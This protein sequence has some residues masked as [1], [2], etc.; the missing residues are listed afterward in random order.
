MSN[1]K[2]LKEEKVKGFVVDFTGT[3][4]GKRIEYTNYGESIRILESANYFK[5]I[6]AREVS[7]YL[8]SVSRQWDTVYRK[9]VNAEVLTKHLNMKFPEFQA[10]GMGFVT[11]HSQSPFDIVSYG[12]NVIIELKSAKDGVKDLLANATLYPDKIAAGDVLSKKLAAG[13]EDTVLDVLVACVTHKQDIVTGYA[14]VDGSYW[15]V[16]QELYQACR[17]YFSDLNEIA[18]EINKILSKKNLF[19]KQ[20]YEGTLNSGVKMKL[21]KLIS[22]TNPVGRLNVLGHWGISE[23]G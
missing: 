23:Q 14:V 22:I 15:G 11:T 21:R 1:L 3:G 10:L 19:A 12:A 7:N 5:K 18:P 2:G 9:D 20:L 6:V 17:D 8:A 13:H 16:T 4:T